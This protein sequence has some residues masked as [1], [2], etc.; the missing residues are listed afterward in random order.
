MKKYMLGLLLVVAMVMVSCSQDSLAQDD[1]VSVRFSKLE[2]RAIDEDVYSVT[3]DVTWGGQDIE[4]KDAKDYYW[5]Y[6][7]TKDDDGFKSGQE[8]AFVAWSDG[9]GLS[10]SK[11]FSTGAWKFELKAYASEADRT[12]GK[13]AIFTGKAEKQLTTA[14]T[15][16]VPMSFTYVEGTGTVDFA[17][18]AT[19]SKPDKSTSVI[20]KVEMITGES[21]VELT[22][23][24]NTANWTGAQAGIASGKKNVEIKVYVDDEETPR[25]STVIGTAYIMHG[26]T[27]KVSGSAV[28][29][30]TAKTI[31]VSFDPEIP[32][33]TLVKAPEGTKAGDTITLGKI[34]VGVKTYGG[35]NI[36]WKVLKV[37]G[38]KALVLSEKV[39]FNMKHY[40]TDGMDEWNKSLIK[41]YLNNV[42]SDGFVSQYGLGDAA[43]VAA[44]ED[45]SG[46]N[47]GDVFLLTMSEIQF[48]YFDDA[49]SRIANDL[50]GTA[51][52]WW[53]RT[54]GTDED[55]MCIEGSDGWYYSEGYYSTNEFGVRPAFWIEI[56]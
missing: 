6:T 51:C 26:L 46:Y 16:T 41:A 53:T 42:G 38:N 44:S 24:E 18:T 19:I 2:A 32:S 48:D 10:G 21:T 54:T 22:N 11:K 47:A 31:D 36:S 45:E 4:I 52:N 33:S 17:I 20:S 56:E 7:A 27:T 43:I 12:E 37:N 9:A 39:L 34:P 3:D 13:K 49:T 5:S 55:F 25:V 29:T 30:L 40:E 8:T 15:V 50:A 14:A 28:I 1:L 23:T 35:Q